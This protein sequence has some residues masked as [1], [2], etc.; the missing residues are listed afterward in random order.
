[1]EGVETREQLALLRDQGCDEYQGNYFSKP[2]PTQEFA[3]LIARA[4]TNS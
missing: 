3:R 1:A 4:S 2:V